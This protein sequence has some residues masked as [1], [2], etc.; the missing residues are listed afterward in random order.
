MSYIIECLVEREGREQR[1]VLPVFFSDKSSA[2]SNACALLRSG[3]S[4][5]RVAGP[6]FE[7]HRTALEAY[8]RAQGPG[9]PLRSTAVA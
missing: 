5:A 7:M 4:V 8:Y 1:V 2:L 6:D 9:R 3:V